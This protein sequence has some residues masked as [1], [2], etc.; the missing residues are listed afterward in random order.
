MPL[1]YEEQI[2]CVDFLSILFASV[3]CLWLVL[4]HNMIN[5]K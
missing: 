1:L 3:F 5:K 4:L 2:V